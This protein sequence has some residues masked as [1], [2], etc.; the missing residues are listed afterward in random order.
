[1]ATHFFIVWLVVSEMCRFYK[2][3]SNL[4]VIATHFFEL[5]GKLKVVSEVCRF[6]I[7]H[8]ICSLFLMVC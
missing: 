1:M 3:F 6:S 2:Y 7:H 4:Y 5:F 8:S